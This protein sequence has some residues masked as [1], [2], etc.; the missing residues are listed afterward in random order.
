MDK[1][2][3]EEIRLH[4][5]TKVT[6]YGQLLR[7]IRILH[8]ESLKDFADAIGYSTANVNG[9]E[10]GRYPITPD[11]TLKV[12]HHYSRKLTREKMTQFLSKEKADG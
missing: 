5:T 4:N 10:M 12:Y 2:M 7:H 1:L 9:I 8:C 3:P 6:P 11:F